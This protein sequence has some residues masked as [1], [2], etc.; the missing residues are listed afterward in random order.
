MCTCAFACTC[1]V[2]VVVYFIVC[3][4]S[5]FLLCSFLSFKLWCTMH[6]IVHVHVTCPYTCACTCTCTCTCTRVHVQLQ[7]VHVYMCM[8]TC[9]CTRTLCR[10]GAIAINHTQ[11]TVMSCQEV[12]YTSIKQFHMLTLIVAVSQ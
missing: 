9:L 11:L 6:V 8:C 7:F 4:S 2:E 1:T 12:L 5:F 10:E 3:D